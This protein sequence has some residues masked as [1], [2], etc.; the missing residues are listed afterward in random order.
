MSYKEWLNSIVVN[1]ITLIGTWCTEGKDKILTITITHPTRWA[2][3]TS[4]TFFK[5]FRVIAEANV[6]LWQYQ[7][8]HINQYIIHLFLNRHILLI[9]MCFVG[10]RYILLKTWRWILDYVTKRW[11]CCERSSATYRGLVQIFQ[12]E[13]YWFTDWWVQKPCGHFCLR[14]VIDWVLLK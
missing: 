14:L 13:R 11:Y 4:C 2:I 1:Y 12:W 6:C 3:M 10:G 8:R 7:L 9:Y 5:S